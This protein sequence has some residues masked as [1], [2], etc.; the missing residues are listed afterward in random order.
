[1]KTSEN[2]GGAAV[3][4]EKSL[5]QR[6]AKYKFL[7]LILA[8]AFVLV[9]VFCYLPMF[10]LIMAFQDY[11]IIAGIA[12]S[13]FVGLDNFIKIFTIPKFLL[14]IKNT[15]LYSSVQIFLGT[16]FPIALALLFNELKCAKFK[17]TVQ[18]ISY[19]PY[20]FSW[21]SAIGM[22]YAFFALDGTYNDI[23]AKIVGEGYKRV[24][25][26]TDA[27]NFVGI[28]F[29][30]NIWKNIGWNSII[31]LAAITGIDSSI[32]EAAVVDGCSRI[33]QVWYITLPCLL[34]TI[35]IIFIMNTAGL[36]TSNFEQVFGFQN[37]YIQEKTEVINTLVYRQ[38]IL[39]GEYS[40]ST[41]FGM[42]QGIVSFILV[43]VTNKIV[44]RV[45]GIGI[46]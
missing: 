12:G 8:P 38:G 5:P 23:M 40:L 2:V 45:T 42:A 15:L 4:R 24:N 46:W 18:T 41:A 27:K 44:K 37:L 10:G 35:A 39:N 43:F 13:R 25:I 14:A 1:M 11:D 22:F 28:L 20:F 26:L 7:Y 30:S 16:P 32:Y 19:L 31:F 6:M 29:W 34:P 17:K 3:I 9:L 36:V 33:K 21:I